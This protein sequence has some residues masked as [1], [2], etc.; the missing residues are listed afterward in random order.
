M[1]RVLRTDIYAVGV[2]LFEMLAGKR[3]FGAE[4]LEQLLAHHLHAPTPALPAQHAMF[5]PIV[6]KLTAK[7][8]QDRYASADA[9]L[10]DLQQLPASR[11]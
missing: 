4:T 5:Q 7:A 2:M 6:N 10:A 9:L 3:P 8:P 1:L 11:P